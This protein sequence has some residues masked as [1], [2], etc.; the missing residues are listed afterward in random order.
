MQIHRV[1]L[2]NQD[3]G[4]TEDLET[5]LALAKQLFGVPMEVDEPDQQR[6]QAQ[7]VSKS[8]SAKRRGPIG[9]TTLNSRTAQPT[10]RVTKPY[11]M[12]PENWEPVSTYIAFYDQISNFPFPNFG[13]KK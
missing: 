1:L 7:I 11:K 3:F 8:K 5:R 10:R 12:I 9:T 6:P 2:S 4:E 13:R